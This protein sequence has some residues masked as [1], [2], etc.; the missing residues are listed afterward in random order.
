M[1]MHGHF[2]HLKTTQWYTIPLENPLYTWKAILRG[3][4]A[5]LHPAACRVPTTSVLLRSRW[6]RSFPR[7]LIVSRPGRSASAIE[8]PRGRMSS[9]QD[10]FFVDHLGYGFW[11]VSSSAMRCYYIIMAYLSRVLFLAP[12][13]SSLRFSPE[14]ESFDQ[15]VST[16][17]LRS[18][19]NTKKLRSGASDLWEFRLKLKF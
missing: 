18:L 3:W 19:G 7:S 16:W 6:I 2:G 9:C 11:M 13:S 12:C 5:S 1:Q 14:R 17:W 15:E 8:R 4:K 10:D